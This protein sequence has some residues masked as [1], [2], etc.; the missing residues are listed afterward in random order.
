MKNETIDFFINNCYLVGNVMEVLDH[1]DMIANDL[2]FEAGMCAGRS[3]F[4]P[5]SVGAPTI[6]FNKLYIEQG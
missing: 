2:S 4:I 5:T 3:G 6:R 1:V